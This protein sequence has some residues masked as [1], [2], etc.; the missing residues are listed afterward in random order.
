MISLTENL[1]NALQDLC[2]TGE[3]TS[4]VFWIDQICIDQE[5][6]EKS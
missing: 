2:N 1:K 3:L 5:D 6:E 4:K